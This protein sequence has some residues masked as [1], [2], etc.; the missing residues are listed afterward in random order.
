VP[1][2]VDQDA[3]RAGLK[4]LA[5]K[6]PALRGHVRS[7]YGFGERT[8]GPMR[9][10]EGPG[11][12]VVLVVSFGHEWRIGDAVRPTRPFERHTSFVGG[13]R[14]SSV[15]TE[16]AGR[17]EGMQVNLTPPTAHALLGLPMHELA[18]SVV[19]L[20][21]VLGA[22]AEELVER[23]YET[24]SWSARFELVQSALVRRLVDARPSAGVSWAWR[25]LV[26]SEGRVRVATLCDELGWSRRRLAARFREEVGVSPKTVARLVRF[27]RAVDLLG[28]DGSPAWARLAAECGYYDQSHLI[29][30]FREITGVTPSAYVA[31]LDA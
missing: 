18:E 14:R 11:S 8:G 31:A 16:H 29:N 23:L 15:L 22:E 26:E 5:P 19:P 10:R 2:L 24:S 9:R 12:S 25:R 13:L 1:E 28:R 27:E 21:A 3:D 4:L 7:L 30:D 6:H 17:S 20:E